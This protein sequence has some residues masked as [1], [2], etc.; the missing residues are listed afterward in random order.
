MSLFLL[1]KKN[2]I[3]RNRT[4]PVENDTHIGSKRPVITESRKK[5]IQNR[6]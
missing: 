4:K 3:N 2:R 1:V 5:K 6:I